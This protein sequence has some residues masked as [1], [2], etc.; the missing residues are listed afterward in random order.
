MVIYFYTVE[1]IVP[2][3]IEPSFG[4]GRIIY[5]LLE[6][7][8]YGRP[9]DAKRNVLGFCPHM[10]PVQCAVLPL[11]NNDSLT[12]I[13]DKI[14]KRLK[15]LGVHTLEDSSSTTIGK[16]YVRADEVG[17][18]YCITIDFD[19]LKDEAVTLRERDSL[20][21]V[22]IKISAIHDVMLKLTNG[23]AYLKDD[24]FQDY[25]WTWETVKSNF[26]I[27]DKASE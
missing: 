15:T 5:G 24:D 11:F 19:T 14:A 9:E 2:H 17:T 20:E 27:F 26:P 7:S 8:Y 6:Q 13:A 10:A 4:F 18:P 21:Q 16:R 22:R 12:P 1:E 23:F 25:G 3:I